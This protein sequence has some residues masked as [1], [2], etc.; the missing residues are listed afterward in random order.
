VIF[1]QALCH[2]AGQSTRWGKRAAHCSLGASQGVSDTVRAISTDLSCL[3]KIFGMGFHKPHFSGQPF[4]PAVRG[5][6]SL[7]LSRLARAA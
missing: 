4:L 1:K 2:C 5:K 3:D 7:A 6:T